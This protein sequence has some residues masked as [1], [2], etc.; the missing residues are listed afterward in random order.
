VSALPVLPK[1]VL[2]A[3]VCG[4]MWRAFFG[5]PASGSHRHAAR[6]A[7]VITAA[8]YGG[9]FAVIAA[10][11]GDLLGSL[12]IVAG[13]E[14]SCLAAWLVRAA[15]GDDGGGDDGGGGGGGGGRG[16]KLPPPID[17][18]EFDRVRRGWGERSPVSR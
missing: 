8:C 10:G 14:T 12:L 1:V 9:G 13:I 5:A 7:L 2:A 6:F 15:R 4:S 16:P 3:L 11:A 18:E 17:W